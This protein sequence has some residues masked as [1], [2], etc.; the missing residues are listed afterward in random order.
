MRTDPRDRSHSYL[1][2]ARVSRGL[3]SQQLA[4]L[5]GVTRT[6]VS[7]WE[8]GVSVPNS[9]KLVELSTVLKCPLKRLIISFYPDKK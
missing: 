9:S 3:S 6:T 8:N 7:R 1:S 2:T 4:D 5:V